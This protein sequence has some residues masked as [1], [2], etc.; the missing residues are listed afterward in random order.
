VTLLAIALFLVLA[1]LLLWRMPPGDPLRPALRP[2]LALAVAWLFIWPYQ[3]PWYEA[4]VICVLVLYPAS[5]LD[6]LVLGRLTAATMSNMPGNPWLIHIPVLGTIDNLVIFRVTPLVLLA[7]V[8]GV[9]GLA[10]SGRW[11][12]R[13]PPVIAQ[14]PSAISSATPVST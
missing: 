7:A 6:W 4:I 14:A 3:L 1:A 2:A 9:V 12:L 5:R 8:I 13:R 10:V 11:G